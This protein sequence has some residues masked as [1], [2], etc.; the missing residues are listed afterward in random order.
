MVREPQAKCC[1]GAPKSLATALTRSWVW[2]L[3]HVA[4]L[5]QIEPHT[6]KNISAS[7]VWRQSPD[8]Q[9]E[10]IQDLQINT[11]PATLDS[12]VAWWRWK[13]TRA[14]MKI[15]PRSLGFTLLN[16]VQALI[17]RM[18]TDKGEFVVDEKWEMFWKKGWGGGESRKRKVGTERLIEIEEEKLATKKARLMIEQWDWRS[19]RNDSRW[20]LTNPTTLYSVM[21][22]FYYIEWFVIFIIINLTS[23]FFQDESRVW[24][25]ASQQH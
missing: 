16:S 20:R 19:R 1:T 21:W 2:H 10:P 22:L 14:R 12:K 24:M 23:I 15:P 17:Q 9:L 11:S 18:S 3:L 7:D 4:S 8:V 13:P 5:V 6:K 25:A